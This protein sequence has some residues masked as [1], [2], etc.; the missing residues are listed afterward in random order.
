MNRKFYFTVHK[1]DILRG[2]ILEGSHVML[3]AASHWDNRKK[4]FMIQRTPPGHVSS[5][6]IDSGGFTAAQRWGEYPWTVEEYVEFIR[7]SSENVRLDF[8]AVMDY[9]CE[10]D[11]NRTVNPTNID[12]IK[13]TVE[14]EALCIA[15][16]PDLPWLPVLQGDNLSEREFDIEY[17]AKNN[18]EI[19]PYMG[20]GSVCKRGAK[21]AREVVRFYAG[22][23]TGVRY[24]A[25][26]L[27]VRA[28]NKCDVLRN[29]KSW[30]SYAW[31]FGRGMRSVGGH[32]IREGE[33]HTEH[34]IRLAKTYL[35]NTVSPRLARGKKCDQEMLLEIY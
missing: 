14:N 16:A 18:V 28:L 4:R 33:S 11:V 31:A 19:K 8:C 23:L 30:D 7:K 20:I 3:V 12:R 13:A 22:T 1:G 2:R 26:G 29:I 9:A 15:A 24:H 6:S 35:E 34:T 21:K 10:P 17:R 25:F 27:D 32:K 5:I